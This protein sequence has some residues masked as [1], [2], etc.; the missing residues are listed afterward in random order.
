MITL[1]DVRRARERIAPYVRKTPLHPLPGGPLLKL[2]NLQVTGSFKA[3]G[4]FNHVLAHQ[5]ACARG[6]ITASSGN[7]GLAVAY[8]AMTLG[9]RAVVVVPED[10]AA[11]K[12]EAIT[13]AGAELI[14]WGRYSEERVP[15]AKELAERRGL[16]YV[17]PY[18]DP[19][20]IAGQGTAGLEIVE[21]CPEVEVVVIP[22]SGGGLISGVAAAVKSLR[23]GVRVIGAEPAGATRFA[24]SRRA[25]RPVVLEKAETIADGLR[26]LTPGHLTWDMTTQYVDEFRDVPDDQT[27]KALR[28]IL[29]DGHVL[30]EPSG[31]VSVACALFGRLAGST[32]VAVVSGGNVDLEVLGLALGAS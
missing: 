22:V 7:H 14:R 31:A 30:A 15:H 10:V 12:A 5:E 17:P 32:A 24:R 19:F 27:L 11:T 29:L 8:V 21:Q 26:V 25:G 20:I 4:A 6:I 2:E 16:H 3:R 18:D 28:R 13:R 1:D 23:P 9:L